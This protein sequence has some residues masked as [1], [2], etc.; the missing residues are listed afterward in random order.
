MR[1]CEDDVQGLPFYNW[2]A[3]ASKRGKMHLMSN[4]DWSGAKE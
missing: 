2:I 3:T 4:Y 1:I